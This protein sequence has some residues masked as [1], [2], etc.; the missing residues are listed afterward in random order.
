MAS[1]YRSQDNGRRF[2][3][4]R[5]H[6]RTAQGDR[7]ISMAHVNQEPRTFRAHKPTMGEM[8]AFLAEER[9]GR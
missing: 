8:A 7:S 2:V 9:R 1:P 6:V 4:S 5:I 3:S